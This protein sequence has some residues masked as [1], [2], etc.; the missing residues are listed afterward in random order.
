[1]K[2]KNFASHILSQTIRVLNTDWLKVYGYRLWLLETFVDSKRFM[3]SSYKAANWI[4][5][6]QTKGF[7]KQGNSFEFH[8]Q[9]KEVYLYPLCSGIAV[10]KVYQS[11]RLN[12]VPLS[13]KSMAIHCVF[14]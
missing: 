13:L 12:N 9:P 1:V 14:S 5:V 8:N 10:L 4:H 11:H 6:G 7:K 2:I 3:A